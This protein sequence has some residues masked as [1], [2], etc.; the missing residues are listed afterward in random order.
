MVKATANGGLTPAKLGAIIVL[1]IVLLVVVVAQFGG[2]DARRRDD[3]PRPSARQD[4]ATDAPIPN[5]P[6]SIAS[7]RSDSW[8]AYQVQDVLQHNPF[9]LPPELRPQSQP[10]GPSVVEAGE[11]VPVDPG[12]RG[13]R[14]RQADLMASLQEQGVDMVLVTPNGRV[15]RVG[16]ATFR[17]GDLVEGLVVREITPTGIVF[18]QEPDLGKP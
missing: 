6:A 16:Q 17:E 10:A 18:V 2:S 7:R 4:Q 11:N 14:R 8:P 3:K 5:E 9:S 12:L 1:S 15:A 13:L